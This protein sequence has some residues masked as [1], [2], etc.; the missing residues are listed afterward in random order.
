MHITETSSGIKYEVEISPVEENEYKQLGEDRYF[1][2]WSQEQKYEVYKLQ[3]SG[4]SEILG[5]VSLERIQLE[6]RVHIRLLTVSIENKGRNKKYNR[7]AGNLIAY[8][9]KI[10][11]REYA[12]LACVSLRPKSEL[13]EHYIKVYGMH[14]TGV[15]LSV[16][17]PEILDLI[18]EYE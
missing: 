2:D 14:K 11:V 15:T 18:Q 1:F 10:A 13:I 3:I 7:I 12:H 17:V 9:A 8:A 16:E 5:L 4:S 6:W